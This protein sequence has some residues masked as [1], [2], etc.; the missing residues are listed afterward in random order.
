[1]WLKKIVCGTVVCGMLAGAAVVAEENAAIDLKDVKCVV[2]PRDAKADKSAE[3]KEGQV[4][5]C[6]DGCKGKF[7]KDSKKFATGANRQ[8]VATKQ[9]EQKACPLSGG[10]IN[11]EKTAEVAGVEVAFCCGDCQGKVAAA[12]GE[13]QVVLVFSEKAF[14]KAFKA[15]PEKDEDDTK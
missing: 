13:E 5:F 11:P 9:Y 4:F 6:C 12:E 2:A 7:A 1:M 15:V 10:D 3:Y 14:E 8:L